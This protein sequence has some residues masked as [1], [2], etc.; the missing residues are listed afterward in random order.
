MTRYA[1][2]C[3]QAALF[4]AGE[5]EVGEGDSSKKPVCQKTIDNSCIT[6]HY[7][8]SDAAAMQHSLV[9]SHTPPQRGWVWLIRLKYTLAWH[10]HSYAYNLTVVAYLLAILWSSPPPPPQSPPLPKAATSLKVLA[11]LPI[12]VVL[13]YQVYM[14]VLYNNNYAHSMPLCSM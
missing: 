12:I 3:L 2:L 6:I 13:M 9:F 4:E 5:G 11:E 10:R 7:L 14:S 1:V 8:W